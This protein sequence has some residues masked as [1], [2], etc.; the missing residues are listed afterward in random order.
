V[1]RTEREPGGLRDTSDEEVCV[2]D[3]AKLLDPEE[4]ML[5]EEL[6]DHEST[7]EIDGNVEKVGSLEALE[8]DDA[9][10]DLVSSIVRDA[11]LLRVTEIVAMIVT[12]VDSEMWALCDTESDACNDFDGSAEAETQL[13]PDGEP[14]SDGDGVLQADTDADPEVLRDGASVVLAAAD[15]DALSLAHDVIENTGDAV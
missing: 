10:K 3:A 13:L 7:T 2:I 14:D 5:G 9:P 1:A 15:T 4:Q 11:R 6:C 12:L 8:D